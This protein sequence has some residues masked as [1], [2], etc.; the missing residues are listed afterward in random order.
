[1][2]PIDL[3]YTWCDSA[4][5]KWSAKREAVSRSIGL[6]ADPTANSDCRF[7]SIGE[8]RYA[9]R[10]A[11]QCVPGVRKVFLVLDDDITPPAW[12]KPDHPRLRI[13][14]LGDLLPD[15]S[16]PCFCSDAIEHRLAFISDLA[17]RYIY[18]NDDC[19]FYRPL[20]PDFF[21]ARDGFPRFRFGGRRGGSR[22]YATYGRNLDNAASLVRQALRSTPSHD[23][24][25]A[26][27]RYPHHCI[28]AYRKSDVLDVY[29]RYRDHIEPMYDFQFRRPENVQRVLYAYDAIAR[30][31]GHFRLARFH[32]KGRRAWWKRL[33][34]PGYADSLQFFGDG[35]KSGVE[36]LRKWR[37]GV[38]C[39]NDTEAV[40]DEDRA[41]LRTALE[42]LFPVPSTFEK[43][44]A[45]A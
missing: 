2:E 13:V 26:F 7:T 18:S 36:M 19:L 25:E 33:L 40:T 34:R 22:V 32:V 24:E 41:W 15:P 17:E 11:G 12:L 35:W 1:M 9:L 28:D 14:R 4:D 45:D 8:L 31:H 5:A 20:K 37:P 27:A 44:G 38:F 29:A 16:K 42:S 43:G 3:V 6:S 39:F 30:G 23:L 21:F 10:S